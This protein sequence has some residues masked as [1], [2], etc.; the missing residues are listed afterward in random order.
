MGSTPTPGIPLL[1][2]AEW[3]SHWLTDYAKCRNLYGL[4]MD[5]ALHLFVKLI[6]LG[7]ALQLNS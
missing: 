6:W 4:A 7:V 2:L 3:I 5:Q 1:G